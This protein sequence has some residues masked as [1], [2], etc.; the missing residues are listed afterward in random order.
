MSNSTLKNESE[1][2]IQSQ[3]IPIF[4]IIIIVA[5]VIAL[6]LL[7]FAF[8]SDIQVMYYDYKAYLAKR[9]KYKQESSEY[10]R[11]NNI[12]SIVKY[13][14]DDLRN[15]LVKE[16]GQLP[17]SVS[18]CHFPSIEWNGIDNTER[19]VQHVNYYKTH[20]D[21]LNY[22]IVYKLMAYLGTSDAPTRCFV[23]ETLVYYII[24]KCRV[25]E[26]ITSETVELLEM[27]LHSELQDV[28][29]S[30]II[31]L[32][33]IFYDKPDLITSDVI[34]RINV[35][36]IDETVSNMLEVSVFI[37][38]VEATLQNRLNNPH[39]RYKERGGLRY[40]ET[41][42]NMYAIHDVN[43]DSYQR[44]KA[45]NATQLMAADRRGGGAASHLNDISDREDIFDSITESERL[46]VIRNSG[47]ERDDRLHL[48]S[49]SST[50]SVKTPPSPSPSSLQLTPMSRDKIT[51]RD[52][53][54]EEAMG[55]RGRKWV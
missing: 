1:S 15:Y 55:I 27:L 44:L 24:P 37:D 51:A 26:D 20:T 13:N 33:E 3:G 19:V 8:A 22:V 25:P 30:T 14:L 35:L 16:R 48:R 43:Y 42:D 5:S 9:W 21:E 41:Y 23:F 45:Q 10:E 38:N 32:G 39:P 17:I 28:R 36:T 47:S 31:V 52:I 49:P 40:K 2:Q 6:F 46:L 18:N 34:M 54:D 11:K 29:T 7:F 50:R 53:K 4:A 12:R